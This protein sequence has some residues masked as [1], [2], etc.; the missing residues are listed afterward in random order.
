MTAIHFF[1]RECPAGWVYPCSLDDMRDCLARLPEQDLEGLWAVG[2]MPATRKDCW[3]DGRYYFGNRPT[4]HLLSYPDTLRFRQPAR[5]KQGNVENGFTV[6]QQYGMRVERAGSRFVCA[7]SADDLRR[8]VVEHVLLHEV[9]HHVYF[10][11]RRQQGYVY[12]PHTVEAEQ[13][14][15]AYALRRQN[16]ARPQVGKAAV[17][18]DVAE[19]P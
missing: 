13:F 5:T 18:P 2:L 16:T 19:K 3:A 17:R 14:A 1:E 15:E 6:Q 10:R 12:R 4:I 11:H 9:G 7:W 8:F